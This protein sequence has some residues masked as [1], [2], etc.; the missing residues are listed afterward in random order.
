MYMY[1]QPKG[2]R[3]V[4]GFVPLQALSAGQVHVY[5]RDYERGEPGLG[6]TLKCARER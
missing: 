3:D 5:N 6:T 4:Y 1:L 2:K